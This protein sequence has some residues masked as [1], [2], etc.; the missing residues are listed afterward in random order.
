MTGEDLLKKL[1]ETFQSSYDIKQ[2]YNINGDIYDAYA[3]FYASSSK[4]VLVKKAE[5]WR[6]NCFEHVFFRYAKNEVTIETIHMFKKQIEEY[7]EPILVRQGKRWPEENHMYT[8]MTAVYIC[9]NGI[10][11]EAEKA[12][13]SFRYIKNYKLTIRGYSEARILAFDL[14]NNRVFGNRAAKELVK[15]YKKLLT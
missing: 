13:R 9:E 14:Q 11:R 10:S 6:V 3:G 1:L 12:I 5:L 15:G 4:Y 2:P 7:I 8:Y